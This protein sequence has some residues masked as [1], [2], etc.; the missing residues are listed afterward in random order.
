MASADRRFAALAPDRRSGSR[1][2]ANYVPAVL[3]NGYAFLSGHGPLDG[4][5]R[6]V[7]VGMLGDEVDAPGGRAAARLATMNL[8]ASL[9]SAVGS[10]DRV[11]AVCRLTGFLRCAPG[12]ADLDD[13]MA[14]SSE[15]LREVF[16]DAV[17]AHARA[18]YAVTECVFGL[19]VTVDAVFAVADR[20]IEAEE[21]Q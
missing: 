4:D 11:G 15:L 6:P 7:V 13:V 9:R 17:G 14:G 8:L 16:G 21:A 19:T 5:G 1:P 3:S 20:I 18:V 12:F 10:L 2:V